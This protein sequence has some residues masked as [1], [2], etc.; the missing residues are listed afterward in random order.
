VK[1]TKPKSNHYGRWEKS[2]KSRIDM[3]RFLVLVFL[4]AEEKLRFT[5]KT[6]GVENERVVYIDGKG[7]T[8]KVKPR[9]KVKLR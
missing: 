5:A 6:L 1:K 8:L 9:T 7:C 4:T 2:W 3:D